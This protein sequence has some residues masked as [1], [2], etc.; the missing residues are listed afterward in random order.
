MK[1]APNLV[2]RSERVVTPSGVEPSTVV[3][4]DGKIAAIEAYDA[5]HSTAK[6]H[7]CGDAVVM[8]GLVDSHV[9][10]NDPG[11]SAWEG[12]AHA[13]RAAAAAGITT[14]VDMPLN[15]SPVTTTVEAL[16]AKEDAAR[17]QCRGDYGFWGGWIPGNTH[18]LVPLLDAGVLGLKCF[19]VPSGLDEFPALGES[20][21][22][23]G[24]PLLAE[25]EAVLLA[26]AESP[27][28]LEAALSLQ[29]GKDPRRY[30]TFL[31]TR[32]E[33]SELE[34]IDLLLN[35]ARETGA[36]VHIV[37][38]ATATALERLEQAR[39]EGLAV[40][41]ETCPHYLG[42][43][44]EDI[45]DGA[46]QFKCAPP[47]RS[48][49]HREGLWRGLKEG[50]LDFI[51]SDHSPCPPEMKCRQ[52]G[53]FLRAWG[54]IASLQLLL[55]AV[56][57]EARKRDFGLEDLGRWLGSGPARL[58]GL[59]GRKGALAVGYDADLVVWNPEE[60][61]V[62]QGEKL[63]HRHPLTPYEGLTLAGVVE[64]TFL[65]GEPIFHRGAFPGEAR[66]VWLRRDAS[67]KSP[68][69]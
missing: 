8:A 26:H 24:L 9:H 46:T 15:S 4:R 57:T 25:R 42:F 21:L 47:I 18:H 63:Q 66:G 29:A 6:I 69:D 28:P 31:A 65:R 17:G 51:A 40:S 45:E 38:L 58:A 34:A 41:V 44:A 60:T 12:F 54:G 43:A 5:P 48:S 37:H 13:G 19:L 62:V 50:I 67:T 16:Q 36:A 52:D 32:P 33:A 39:R 61:F 2:L 11:R 1:E 56:W 10:I 55:P 27:G 68:N 35:L 22:R 3:V 64:T 53:D 30:A 14:V 20:E 7:Q 23:R 59:T 49:S